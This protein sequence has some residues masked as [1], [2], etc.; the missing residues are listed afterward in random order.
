[1][2]LFNRVAQPAAVLLTIFNE[3]RSLTFLTSAKNKVCDQN[4]V[5]QSLQ[6]YTCTIGKS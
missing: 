1:M 3:K 4:K 2:L 6:F 5:L